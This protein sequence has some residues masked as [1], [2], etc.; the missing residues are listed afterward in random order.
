MESS[1]ATAPM[2]RSRFAELKGK[3]LAIFLAAFTAWTLS[4]M[5]QSLFGYVVPALIDDFGIGLDTIGLMISASFVFAIFSVTLIGIL[6][7]LWGRRLMLGL[8]LG[9]SA[10]CVA[11]QAFM[12][13]VFLLALM[14]IIGFGLGAGLSPITN[15]LVA[16]SSPPRFRSILMALLQ[17]AYP[18]G[19]FVASILVVPILPAFGWRGTFM[20]AFAVVPVAYMLYR[21]IPENTVYGAEAALVGPKGLPLRELAGPVYRRRAIFCALAFFV[22]GGATSGT[23]FYLPKFFQDVR[24]YEETTAALLVGGAY[25]VAMI[26]YVGGALVGNMVLGRR[27]TVVVW[28]WLGGLGIA[29]TTWLPQTVWQDFLIFGLTTIFFYGTSCVLTIYMVELFPTRLRATGAAVCGSA[30]VATGFSIFPILV[31]WSVGQVG[32]QWS[33]S[34]IIVPAMLLTGVF[35][36]AIG[37]LPDVE[38]RPR[39]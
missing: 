22:Y 11:A 33:F 4:N 36:L 29:L 10:L 24:G 18:F 8:A 28:S 21:I 7:D 23:T 19:W 3:P 37:E 31:A 38:D 1:A 16:E 6:A 34:T 20:I 14:R 35:V 39:A 17:C 26:G 30:A 12:P 15:A 27:K 2:T 13:N 25:A 9:L 32:W 5:D